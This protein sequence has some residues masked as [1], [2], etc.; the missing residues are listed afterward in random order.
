MAYKFPAMVITSQVKG[1]CIEVSRNGRITYVAE[2]KPVILQGSRI[3][4]VTLH[5]YEFIRNLKLNIGDEVII[6]KAG[7]VIPQVSQ[8]IKLAK[9]DSWS[10]PEICPSCQGKLK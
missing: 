10:P 3:S 6:K 1:I 2:I 5:N 7:D 4:K 8:V 9:S